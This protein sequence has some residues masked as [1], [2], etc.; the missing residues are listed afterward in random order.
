V[1]GARA[2]GM[3]ALRFTGADALRATLGELKVL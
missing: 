3:Q 2:V 1:E